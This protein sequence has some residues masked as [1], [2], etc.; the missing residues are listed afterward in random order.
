[1]TGVQTCAL[2]IYLP[3]E[4]SGLDHS[5]KSPLSPP[6]TETSEAQRIQHALERADGNRERAAQSLGMSRV[7]L[8]RRMRT[9]GLLDPDEVKRVEP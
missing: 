5:G 6:P 1:M 7:T 8:W 9:Y 3:P 4:V 2:P